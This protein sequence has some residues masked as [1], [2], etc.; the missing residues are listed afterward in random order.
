MH[1]I[2]LRTARAVVFKQHKN[3]TFSM[4]IGWLPGL[5]AGVV[6]PLSGPIVDQA[7]HDNLQHMC[8]P[9][10]RLLSTVYTRQ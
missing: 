9:D 2:L 5:S 8:W 6:D 10:S 7:A 1:S 3:L 4:I